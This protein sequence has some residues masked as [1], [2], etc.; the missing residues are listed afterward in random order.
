MVVDCCKFLYISEDEAFYP[1]I[2]SSLERFLKCV[3]IPSD[4]RLRALK[5]FCGKTVSFFT[6]T[7]K[8]YTCPDDQLVK[9]LHL[10]FVFECD[11]DKKDAVL[12]CTYLLKANGVTSEELKRLHGYL[13]QIGDDVTVSESVRATALGCIVDN[14]PDKERALKALCD[15]KNMGLESSTKKFK[16]IYDSS[17]NVHDSSIEQSVTRALDQLQHQNPVVIL[18]SAKTAVLQQ[19]MGELE[20]Q[21]QTHLTGEKKFR[22]RRTL[23]RM[24]SDETRFTSHNLVLSEILCMV[25][26]TIRSFPNQ[27]EYIKRLIEELDDMDSTDQSQ[28][29]T[30]ELKSSGCS[31]GYAARL[32]NSLSGEY[33]VIKISW[34]DQ[35]KSNIE[36]RLFKIMRDLPEGDH[37]GLVLA[38]ILQSAEPDEIKAYECFVDEHKTVLYEELKQEFVGGGWL[39]HRE[40]DGCFQLGFPKRG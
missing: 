39:S 1:H 5:G 24:L 23:N 27:N 12:A 40:F 31:W 8:I 4:V 35:V 36:G 18:V 22:V 17:Q 15:L 6:R 38:G 30:T 20:V 10:F 34:Q 29:P 32:V 37:K 16:T 28:G 14:S 25:W 7:D 2:N 26:K 33:T 19:V 9:A 3:G 11:P 21:I 13:E